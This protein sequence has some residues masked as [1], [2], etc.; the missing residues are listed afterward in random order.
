MSKTFKNLRLLLVFL[1]VFIFAS[2][3][4]FYATSESYATTKVVSPRFPLAVI[5]EEGPNL[6][7]WDKYSQQA[8]M[9]Q[10]RLIANSSGGVF[11]LS[12]GKSFILTPMEKGRIL[13]EVRASNARLF[14]EYFIDAGAVQPQRLRVF[15]LALVLWSSAIA[16][17]VTASFGYW[18]QGRQA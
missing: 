10:N 18:R 17:L 6:I 1:V 4:F 15:D 2:G 14:A 13:L 5:T 16:L 8:G 12:S 7:S 11:E 3:A 9:Y